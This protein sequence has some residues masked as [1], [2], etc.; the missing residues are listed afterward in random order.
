MKW[1]ISTLGEI[2]KNYGG[3][4]QTGPFGS[5]LHQHD[6]KPEGTPVVMPKNIVNDKIDTTSIARIS[7][8]DA[9]RL[10]KHKLN[11]GDLILPRRGDLN[12]RAICK[13][14][15]EGWLCGTGC[16]K[17]RLNDVIVDPS[18]LYYYFSLSHVVE[19]ILNK[20]VGSTMLNLSGS[21][22]SSTELVY[23]PLPTQ[24]KIASILS[25][26]DDLIENNLKRIKL[27]EDK[28]QLHYKELLQGSSSWEKVKLEQFVSVVKGRKPINVLNQ[29]EEDSQ[30]YLLLD[31][32][33][34]GKTL[35]T[36]DLSLPQSKITDVLMCMDGARS[37]LCFRGM[38]GAIGSTMAIWRSNSE[39]V[40][41]EFL[42]QFKK[43]HESAITQGNTGAA[44]PH[45]NRKFILDMEI[46]MPSKKE[47]YY[48]DELTIPIIKLINT[49]HQQ[50]TKLRE[51]RDIL[52][53]KLMKG[54][55][56]V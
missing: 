2:V 31:T 47:A 21:I 48:F 22:L 44:I 7:E 1:E 27:L 26:Y 28:L 45:A 3:K 23:P 35:Y 39:R 43:Q 13:Q 41:G 19:N 54:Q 8:S 37:G 5:Q 42:F 55:I 9:D 24:R 20:A 34:K 36:T 14:E 11:I 30:L 6:Y 18:Y 29:P 16:L 4:I 32:I 25:A 15:N 33:E 17:I 51:A 40:N 50:N 52:L 56:E 12:K 10:S 53:P 46:A 49:L 38:T